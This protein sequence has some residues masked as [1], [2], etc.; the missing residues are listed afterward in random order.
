MYNPIQHADQYW[1]KL[2]NEQ[3]LDVFNDPRIPGIKPNDGKRRPTAREIMFEVDLHAI[4]DKYMADEITIVAE[5]R[6]GEI[7]DIWGP[8]LDDMDD[9]YTPEDDKPH[10]QTPPEKPQ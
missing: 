4:A 2:M 5:A 1:D 10:P 3:K 6:G 7:I 9:F 8:N